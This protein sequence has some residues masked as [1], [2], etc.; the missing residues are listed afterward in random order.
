MLRGQLL[1]TLWL[2]TPVLLSGFGVAVAAGDQPLRVTVAEP[3]REPLLLELPVSGITSANPG[4]VVRARLEGA[5]RGEAATIVRDGRLFKLA[6]RSR[7]PTVAGPGLIE[8]SVAAETTRVPF[9]V[10]T[11]DECVRA[12]RRVR[13]LVGEVRGAMTKDDS[14][15]ANLALSIRNEL[16]AGTE[17]PASLAALAL[18]LEKTELRA[19]LEAR[20]VAAERVYGSGAGASFVLLVRADEVG[21]LEARAAAGAAGPERHEWARALAVDAA[22]LGD[23]ARAADGARELA[24]AISAVAEALDGGDR[25]RILATK[26]ALATER[27]R[28][29][30]AAQARLDVLAREA[31]AVGVPATEA[32]AA[33]ARAAVARARKDAWIQALVRDAAEELANVDRCLSYRPPLNPELEAPLRASL[34]ASLKRLRQ[35]GPRE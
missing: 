16:A 3:H 2:L 13:A 4:T 6:L 29:V 1:R 5:H 14:S 22:F 27:A 21:L 7:G 30:S 35:G 17:H 11:A 18:A 25:P 24:H 33:P 34:E 8:V 9:F 23:E 10:G 26:T 19:T 32:A 15:R 20:L 12:R 31:E 28:I